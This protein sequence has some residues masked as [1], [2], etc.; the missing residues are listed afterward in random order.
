MNGGGALPEGRIAIW[1]EKAVLTSQK[2]GGMHAFSD[3]SRG[4]QTI[5]FATLSYTAMHK[6]NCRSIITIYDACLQF[7]AD[8][9]FVFLV[10][11][12]YYCCPILHRTSISCQAL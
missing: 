9:Y 11:H 6:I 12:A 2:G 7:H 10:Q 8:N 4:T 1:A 5:F 3:L